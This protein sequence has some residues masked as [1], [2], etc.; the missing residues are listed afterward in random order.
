VVRSIDDVVDP[1]TLTPYEAVDDDGS[2]SVY[3][4]DEDE[5]NINEGRLGPPIAPL[6]RERSN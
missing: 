5:A 4:E 1:E 3:S 2:T 6:S